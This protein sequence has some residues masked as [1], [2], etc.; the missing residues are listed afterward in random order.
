MVDDKDQ[1]WHTTC[2]TKEVN[3]NLSDVESVYETLLLVNK[4]E[5]HFNVADKNDKNMDIEEKLGMWC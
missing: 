5:K 4:G 3:K 2:A 1:K